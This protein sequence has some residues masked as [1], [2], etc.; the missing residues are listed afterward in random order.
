MAKG[1]TWIATTVDSS[2][3]VTEE[4]TRKGESEYYPTLSLQNQT[5]ELNQPRN[6]VQELCNMDE[7]VQNYTLA[8]SAFQGESKLNDKH[9]L[10]LNSIV[11]DEDVR[12]STQEE[13][14]VKGVEGEPL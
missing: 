3:N 5:Q 11:D 7:D 2:R 12:S 4:K 14:D 1:Y 13:A 8:Q 9:C 6:E 10:K